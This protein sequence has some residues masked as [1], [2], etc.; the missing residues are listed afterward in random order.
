MG[1]AAVSISSVEEAAGGSIEVALVVCFLGENK[2]SCVS[3]SKRFKDLL[4]STLT[5]FC[6][7]ASTVFEAFFTIGTVSTFTVSFVFARGLVE[8]RSSS[9]LSKLKTFLLVD[10]DFC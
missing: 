8:K 3:S 5:I 10:A 9:L 2:S 1:L 6:T 4:D 7:G